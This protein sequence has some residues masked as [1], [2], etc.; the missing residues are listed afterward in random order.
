MNVLYVVSELYPL[1]KTGGLGDVAHSLP[2]ALQQQGANVRILLPGY[3]DVMAQMKGFRILGW[4]EL[5]GIGKTHSARVLEVDH[6]DMQVPLWL[7]DCPALF[8]RPGNPYVDADGYDWAD[9]GERF[10]CFSQAAAM[11]SMGALQ[12]GWRAD[13]V[14]SH[15]WQCGLVSAFL[16]EVPRPPRRIFTIHNLAFGGHFS[17]EVFVGLHLPSH[18][19]HPEGVEFHGGFSMLKAGLIYADAITTVSPTYAEEICTSAFGYGMEGVLSSRRYKLSGILNGIDTEVWDPR[20]DHHL[21]ARYSVKQRGPAKA[22]NKAA[23]F[24]QMGTTANEERMSAPL[25][26]MVGRLVEQ[27]GIDLILEA[28]PTLIERSDANFVLLGSGNRQFKY[29]LKELAASYPTRI[30]CHI[31]YSEQ[32]AHL[33]EAGS[34][35]FLMP[36]RYEPCGLNQMYSLCY[37]TPPIVNNTGGLA[38]TVVDTTEATLK[39]NSATGFVMNKPTAQEL[40]DAVMRALALYSDKRQ[41][42][43]IQ[44][45]AMQQSFSW[46]ESAAKYLSLYHGNH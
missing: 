12:D 23:L 37:G 28:I 39:D 38:D 41:W 29:W 46:E 19:W 9:N 1:N 4:M 30:F 21:A 31:G 17:H 45:N 36:S 32:L 6:P 34:D 44:R 35:M 18:W 8:D 7:L 22:K 43:Q 3:R 42:Q 15:D 16:E 24:E 14:H 27:K 33:I 25:L 5:R 40:I 13:V 20:Q 11:V 2:I 10:A 26:G